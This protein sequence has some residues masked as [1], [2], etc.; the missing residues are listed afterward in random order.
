M[1]RWQC[2]LIADA[3]ETMGS[4]VMCCGVR[5]SRRN[6]RWGRVEGNFVT[7]NGRGMSFHRRCPVAYD[8]FKDW[9]ESLRHKKVVARFAGYR[10][11]GG[12]PLSDGVAFALQS[13]GERPE[14]HRVIVVLTDGVP[15]EKAVM[16]RLVRQAHEAGIWV[17]GVGIG[18]GTE[19]VRTLYP[20]KNVVVNTLRDLPR[21][22]LAQIE[23]VVF[24]KRGGSRA[25]LDS[26]IIAR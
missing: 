15:N 13:I 2:S 3:F 18:S 17:I 4:P 1:L 6:A 14:R 11:T 22:L 9:D 26:Q 10:A 25:A 19:Q 20:D 5:D 21:E 16:R 12:T 7:P 24:P 8:L 23:S